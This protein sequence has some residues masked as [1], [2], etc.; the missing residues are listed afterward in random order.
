MLYITPT[1]TMLNKAK[2]DT[3]LLDLLQ[4]PQK[5]GYVVQKTGNFTPYLLIKESIE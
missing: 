1:L 4:H 5:Y 2:S 3:V